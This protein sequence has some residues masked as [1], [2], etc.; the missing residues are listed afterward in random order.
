MPEN[1]YTNIGH[2][3]AGLFVLYTYLHHEVYFDNYLAT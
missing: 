1:N 2:S 3:T